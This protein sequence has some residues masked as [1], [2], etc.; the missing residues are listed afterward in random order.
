MS[1]NAHRQS[2]PALQTDLPIHPPIR[3]QKLHWER[4]PALPGRG[5]GKL[6]RVQRW[7]FRYSGPTAKCSLPFPSALSRS[8]PPA[9]TPTLSFPT[10]KP[11]AAYPAAANRH[12]QR[13]PVS[14]PP[15]RIPI[16]PPPPAIPQ[17]T[18]PFGP[19]GLFTPTGPPSQTHAVV[20]VVVGGVSRSVIVDGRPLTSDEE[21][22]VILC[23][24][25]LLHGAITVPATALAVEQAH[26]IELGVMW[27][28]WLH[29]ATVATR[30]R[31]CICVTTSSVQP[32]SAR[33]A[34]L[35]YICT[36]VFTSQESRDGSKLHCPSLPNKKWE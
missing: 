10:P 7:R 6:Y 15:P 30:I 1:K 34:R 26:C 21:Q 8:A 14:S 22:D 3:R 17:A 19:A 32:C 28:T 12:L 4:R 31:V 24:F 16:R 27:G 35:V 11:A 20:T 23:L 9:T 13:P 25:S 5:P 2:R 33:L 18:A 29:A 36:A